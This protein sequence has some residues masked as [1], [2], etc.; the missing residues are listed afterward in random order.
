MN[1]SFIYA[2]VVL[3]KEQITS[4]VKNITYVERERERGAL[5]V[6]FE[7]GGGEKTVSKQ[8]STSKKKT[9]LKSWKS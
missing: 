3:Y 5:S 2:K 6:V 9:F 8:I 7:R 4:F 1:F